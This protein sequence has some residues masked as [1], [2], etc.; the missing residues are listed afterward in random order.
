MR[1]PYGSFQFEIAVYPWTTNIINLGAAFSYSGYNI[2][3]QIQDVWLQYEIYG[4]TG[5]LIEH[6]FKEMTNPVPG[7]NIIGLD[8]HLSYTFTFKNAQ[9]LGED[10]LSAQVRIRWKKGRV[11]WIP[12]TSQYAGFTSSSNAVRV[13]LKSLSGESKM[14]DKIEVITH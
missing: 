13:S 6:D 10:Q 2:R 1:N 9:A 3:D 12:L 11:I 8:K 4:S 14:A 5:A 7:E